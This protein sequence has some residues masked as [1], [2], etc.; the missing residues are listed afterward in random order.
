MRN[1]NFE[2]SNTKVNNIQIEDHL[3]YSI[4]PALLLT[5]TVSLPTNASQAGP[6]VTW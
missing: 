3:I 4:Q 5:T 1:F 6:Y 2:C